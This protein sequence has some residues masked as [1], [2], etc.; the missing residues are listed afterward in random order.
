MAPFHLSTTLVILATSLLTMVHQIEASFTSHTTAINLRKPFVNFHEN[1]SGRLPS[2]LF[3]P[4]NSIPKQIRNHKTPLSY[5]I[6]NN[7]DNSKEKVS[8]SSTVVEDGS[9]L[10]VA[11]VVL[12][13][14]FVVLGNDTI[15]E[16]RIPVWAVFATASIAAGLS[17]LIRYIRR[18]SLDDK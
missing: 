5:K 2:V 9:P 11:I 15:D 7:N 18:D 4:T 16:N 14:S 1:T 12:G 10:G 8:K 6:K 3:C 13:G 17:R